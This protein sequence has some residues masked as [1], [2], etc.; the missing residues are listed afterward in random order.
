LPLLLLA[1][2]P[3]AAA[4]QTNSP[5][6][7]QPAQPK[8]SPAAPAQAA[9]AEVANISYNLTMPIDEFLDEVYAPLVG[10]AQLRAAPPTMTNV[11]NNQPRIIGPDG[12]IRVVPSIPPK[13]I[14]PALLI[15]IRTEKALTKSEA[16]RALEDAMAKKGFTILPVGEKFF[17]VFLHGAEWPE[18]GPRLSRGVFLSRT[19]TCAIAHEIQPMKTI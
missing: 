17:K 10:R 2:L 1:A 4:A 5:A 9:P 19:L 14:D 11:P 7:A 15:T 8:S 6:P 18:G 13:T 12:Q 16:I 3:L